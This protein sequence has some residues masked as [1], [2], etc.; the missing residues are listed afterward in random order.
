[1]ASPAISVDRSF[2]EDPRPHGSHGFPAGFFGI[3]RSRALPRFASASAR[4]CSGVRLF[5]ASEP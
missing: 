1:M 4:T 3:A 2:L 5:F